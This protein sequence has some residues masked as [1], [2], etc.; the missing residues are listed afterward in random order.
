MSLDQEIL[1]T[2]DGG[3]K[4]LTLNMPKKRNAIGPE[5]ALR[6]ARE[7]EK[8]AEDGTRVLVVTGA[9]G[10]F[11]AGA[12]LSA[13]PFA[14][15]HA[16]G[17]EVPREQVFDETVDR[18]YHRMIRAV[19]DLPRPVIAAVD[20]VA[21]GIGC[22]LALMA[23]LTLAAS[24]AR[25]IELFVN[26]ALMPDGGSS[27]ILPRLVGMK[28]AMEMV[29]TGDPVL[30]PEALRLGMVTRLCPPEELMEEAG[31]LARKLSLG[32]VKAM[33]VIKK[34]LYE[35]QTLGFAES[36]ELECR[37]QARLM[38]QPDFANAARAFFHKKKPT[39]S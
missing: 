18:N 33:G 17:G 30:A 23:D 13:E 28:K 15:V 3:V 32:P 25:F 12:D 36:L 7:V 4:T 29:L 6:I 35:A 24:S 19:H 5:H 16:D 9:G 21:A 10:S 20:G 1:T 14:R 11:C 38:T 2:A 39:F 27:Y 31:K 34:T 22:S 26:I 37:R 8:S